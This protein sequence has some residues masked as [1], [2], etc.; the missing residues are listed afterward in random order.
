MSELFVSDSS[1]CD[2]GLNSK[3][4]YTLFSLQNHGAV[5]LPILT[6]SSHPLLTRLVCTP[7]T[8]ATQHISLNRVPLISASL[9]SPNSTVYVPNG[10]ERLMPTIQPMRPSCSPPVTC[11]SS[12]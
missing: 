11:T 4:M 6:R 9:P 12:P 1:P 10:D 2:F 5:S 8:L 3:A 7:L